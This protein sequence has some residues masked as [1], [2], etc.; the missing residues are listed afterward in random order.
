[1]LLL[2]MTS[3]VTDD[4]QVEVA[5]I[6]EACDIALSALFLFWPS[7]F[8]GC[9]PVEVTGDATDVDCTIGDTVARGDVC[10]AGR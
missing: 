1:M 2:L 4:S 10:T 7:D 8:D 9:A 3:C 5:L 6:L